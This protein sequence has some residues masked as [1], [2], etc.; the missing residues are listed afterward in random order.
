MRIWSPA[1]EHLQRRYARRP[2]PGWLIAMN[3]EVWVVV[4]VRDHPVEEGQME[5]VV[6]RPDQPDPHYVATLD[7]D[8]WR[9]WQALPEHYAV[10][11][12]CGDL[13]PCK[14]HTDA[15]LAAEQA[16]RM[17]RELRLLPGCCP[18]CQEPVTSRQKSITFEG[19]YVRNPL[20]PVDVA[21]HLRR[22]CR[23]EAA[24]YEEAWVKADLSR[25]RSLLTLRCV[26]AL[27]V[28]GDGHVECHGGHDCP[29]IY[30][31]HGHVRSCYVE[32][33]GC[34]RACGS[35][36]HG[37]AVTGY[38]DDPRAVTRVLT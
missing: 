29:S 6:H 37:C 10:C 18:A 26:G 35:R 9:Q 15:I 28:C 33:L 8:G 27:V 34:D 38:P 30:A 7:R 16:I 14:A 32:P 23:S 36:S 2:E 25:P 20:G 22:A 5:V 24:R 4:D 21:F 1:V 11:R 13:A 12:L 19:E 17:E 3:R 31:H